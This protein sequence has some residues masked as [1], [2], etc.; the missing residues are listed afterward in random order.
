MSFNPWGSINSGYVG[1]KRSVRSQSAIDSY[2][3]PLSMIS[4]DI[5]DDFLFEYGEDYSEADYL[6][7]KDLSVAKWKYVA[8]NRIFA[9][10]W[11][12]TGSYFNETDHYDL[13]EIAEKIVKLKDDLEDDYK[14]YKE[15]QKEVRKDELQN[16]EFGVIRVQVWGGSRRRPKIIG[17]DKVA[18]IVIGGWLFY[19]NGHST[20]GRISKYKTSAN[21]V[22]WFHKYTSYKD[23]VAKHPEY[24]KSKKVFNRLIKEKCA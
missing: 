22:E 9:S 5:I 8:K 21:K 4:K 13:R 18:G 20:I 17:Y 3:M 6:L 14:A 15:L 7:L 16:F 2:E 24:K 19:K 11:H 12:H 1:A 10:S 23:L